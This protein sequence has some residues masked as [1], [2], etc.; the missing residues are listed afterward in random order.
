MLKDDS[1]IIVRRSFGVVVVMMH[2]A[3]GGV[4]MIVVPLVCSCNGE[5]FVCL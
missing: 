4:V 3:L 5:Y 1:E 2:L